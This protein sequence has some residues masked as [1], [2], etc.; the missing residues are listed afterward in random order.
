MAPVPVL[1][2]SEYLVPARSFVL[3]AVAYHA[4]LALFLGWAVGVLVRDIFQHRIIGIDDILGAFAGYILLGFV[5]GS[6]CATVELLAPG[7][8]SVSPDIR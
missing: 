4:L 1:A 2:L 8:F 7:S 3:A 6:L 5:W